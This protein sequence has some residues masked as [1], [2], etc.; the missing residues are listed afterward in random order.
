MIPT[1]IA[2]VGDRVV[3]V[4]DDLGGISR[5]LFVV[6][7]RT[8]T[9]RAD[10]AEI[11]RHIYRLGIAALPLLLCGAAIIGGVVAMQGLGYVVRYNATE[12]Y[13]W[14]AGLSAYREVGPL[15]L[16][17]TLAAR[18]GTKNAAEL[19]SMTANERL[20]ALT[21]L[22]LDVT[23]V[24]VVPRVLAITITAAIVY[25]L[26]ATTIL[27]VSFLLAAAL[28]DQII[29]I[30]V[31]S[32]LEYIPAYQVAEGFLRMVAFG[33]VVALVSTYFG[34]RSGHDARSIGAAVYASSVTSMILIVV[35]NLY[36]SL[37]AGAS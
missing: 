11:F 3:R 10:R 29:A 31:H 22:G 8:A 15:L 34:R 24:V 21:A 33:A 1:S 9:L 13:G 23:N 25:P 35:M 16:G 19:A 30:S 6:V 32:L 26:A 36:L 28:G 17:L 20:D 12:V 2:A 27:A 5:L 37:A 14:A 7:A 4:V 18:V